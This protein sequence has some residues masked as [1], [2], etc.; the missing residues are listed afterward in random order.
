MML[1][2]LL[3]QVFYLRLIHNSFGRNGACG[4]VADFLH[5]MPGV[6]ARPFPRNLMQLFRCVQSFPKRM[7]GFAFEFAF[8]R[9]DDVLRIGNQFDLARFFQ[10]FQTEA[11]GHNFGLLVRA[12][13]EV[14]AADF[15]LAEIFQNGDRC[16]ARF[17]ATIAK[18]AAITNDA[19]LFHTI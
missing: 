16:R 15:A 2:Y 14:F 10:G 11:G 13:A 5:G 8:H 1:S 6:A 12:I 18:T 3:K 19:N 7:I 17:A 9:S 4:F